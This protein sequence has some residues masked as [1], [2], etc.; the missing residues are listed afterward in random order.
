MKGKDR[1]IELA[2]RILEDAG[3]T[4]TKKTGPSPYYDDDEDY[5]EEERYMTPGQGEAL[6]F[7]ESE[8]EYLSMSEDELLELVRGKNLDSKNPQDIALVAAC[9]AS[10][11]H[12]YTMIDGMHWTEAIERL[13][14]LS[15]RSIRSMK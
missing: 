5:D 13:T 6:E 3:Y 2:K 4:V 11:L 7:L 12:R 9:E 15:M 1:Q 8:K 10:N 14:R